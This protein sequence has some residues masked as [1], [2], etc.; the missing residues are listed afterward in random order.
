[1]IEEASCGKNAQ[2]FVTT[3]ANQYQTVSEYMESDEQFRESFKMS[4]IKLS[5]STSYMYQ[6]V[7]SLGLVGQDRPT[8]FATVM[9]LLHIVVS[10]TKHN[11]M[12]AA[13]LIKVIVIFS[14]LIMG[15]QA[16]DFEV[17]TTAD[18]V[19]I[20]TN[21]ATVEYAEI[22]EIFPLDPIFNQIARLNGS[23]SMIQ[24]LL[25]FSV[26]NRDCTTLGNV[27]ANTD[28]IEEL[29]TIAKTK[30]LTYLRMQI[31]ET[32]INHKFVG[33]VVNENHQTSCLLTNSVANIQYLLAQ[34]TIRNTPET[35]Q[36]IINYRDN[37]LLR[38]KD[39]YKRSCIRQ[40]SFPSRFVKSKFVVSQPQIEN[41]AAICYFMLSN[42]LNAVRHNSV[43]SI[44]QNLT[45][46]Q[47]W[48]FNIKTG[49]CELIEKI[50]TEDFIGKINW[51][52]EDNLYA[53]TGLATCQP[54]EFYRS[55]PKIY[56][57]EK[58]TNMHEI[59]RF[60][61]ENASFDNELSRCK[62]LYY[63]L[64]APIVKQRAELS[65]F[66][67][68]I[69]E[70]HKIRKTREVRSV[71]LFGLQIAKMLVNAANTVEPS[72]L[73][74]MS[75][76][77]RSAVERLHNLRAKLTAAGIQNKLVYNK[78]QNAEPYRTLNLESF[79]Q[80]ARSWQSNYGQL[81]LIKHNHDNF[82]SQLTTSSNNLETYV[83]KLLNNELPVQNKTRKFIA[84]QTYIFSSYI[85]EQKIVRQYIK[86]Q[87]GYSAMQTT[88]I[89]ITETAFFKSYLWQ[90]DVF[91]GRRYQQSNQCLRR[92]MQSFNDENTIEICKA[93]PKMYNFEKLG[94]NIYSIEQRVNNI[95][96]K[97][98]VI[99]TASVFEVRCKHG[100]LLK[101]TQ[102]LAIFMI[103][104]DCSFS[105]GGQI[106]IQPI[107]NIAGFKP[108]F[109]FGLNKTLVRT[110]EIVVDYHKIS[111]S[112]ITASFCLIT[113]II[114]IIVCVKCSYKRTEIQ[115]NYI[116]PAP[117]EMQVLN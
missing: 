34:N 17:K 102:G 104:N 46:C 54:S 20:S 45:N 89:P 39:N 92:L 15:V 106:I 107:L 29:I 78:N 111:N 49:F 98:I 2:E 22:T 52:K 31:S 50:S 113:T 53:M 38:F 66:I 35:D 83:L 77:T 42:F 110:K 19:L 115:Y 69:I 96:G 62:N 79:L 40:G 93:A 51:E 114:L 47:A 70:Q 108:I 33:Y 5:N 32:G 56:A 41:C 43:S 23:L 80:V 10:P 30:N 81:Q 1:M 76:V 59:C 90:S 68:N 7:G 61:S 65:L 117:E 75:N 87:P 12:M 18:H 101:S 64:R 26:E 84:N 48:S 25:E 67:R 55:M 72:V 28:S 73:N 16:G 105:M 13:F 6:F 94:E 63:T 109:V 27:N 8:S 71:I 9:N 103:S 112:V 60:S 116:A 82:I 91:Q 11:R 58:L 14:C 37:M 4:C 85:T 21:I 100:Q 97:I 57:N 99:N 74:F 88:L 3:L 95:T 24:G 36:Q 86:T 44:K